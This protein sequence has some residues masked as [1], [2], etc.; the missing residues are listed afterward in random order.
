MP[1]RKLPGRLR[2]VDLFSGCGGLSLGFSRAGFEV[3]A[4]YDN[5]P[6]AVKVYR[7]NF[8]H[9]VHVIDLGN[10]PAAIKQ[11]RRESPDLIIGGPPC[12]DFSIAGKRVESRRASLTVAFAKICCGARVPIAVMENVYNIEKS[13]ALAQAKRIFK[14]AGYGLTAQV[15]DASLAGVPQMRRRLFLI[16]HLGGTDDHFKQELVRRL[17]DKPMTVADHFGKRLGVQYYYA[18]PRNYKRRAVFSVH[19][20]SATIRRVNRPIPKTYVR[21]PADKARISKAVRVLTTAERAEIQTFPRDFIFL[22]SP[23]QQE[24]LVANAVPVQLAFFVA[25][26]IADVLGAAS[27]RGRV[28]SGDPVLTRKKRVSR[29][30]TA[31]LAR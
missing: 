13:R 27:Q 2:T 26:T 20:P 7:Q 21:H 28:E 9:P 6:L 18:H 16:A 22:G 23:S 24:H 29:H 14:K 1:L 17:A 11:I 10:V 4:A 8:P 30:G 25:K 5:W 19:E 3:V 15:I 31:T 12:Q